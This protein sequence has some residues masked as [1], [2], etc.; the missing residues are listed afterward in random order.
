MH[1]LDVG[2]GSG[3]SGIQVRS[4]RTKVVNFRAVNCFASGVAVFGGDGTEF[5]FMGNDCEIINVTLRNTNFGMGEPYD[6]NQNWTQAG[7]MRDQ[8][9][10]NTYRNI[11]IDGCGGPFFYCNQASRLAKL[12]GG[13]FRNG[14]QVSV[15]GPAIVLTQLPTVPDRPEFKDIL[16]DSTNGKITDLVRY[17]QNSANC[18][19]T[20]ENVRGVGITGALF[21][22]AYVNDN[23]VNAIG[24][25]FG[26]YRETVPLNGATTFSLR[27]RIGSRF[28]VN[29]TASE[30][31]VTITD[32][33]EGQRILIYGGTNPLNVDHGVGADRIFLKGGTAIVLTSNQSVEI[34]RRGTLW[35]EI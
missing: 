32:C 9:L 21:R 5:D 30:H 19:P 17:L 16:V 12:T 33:V 7:A 20:T 22:S 8:G 35:Y 27:G 25:G 15:A 34:E 3:R 29:P 14:R 23:Q 13:T 11:E 2:I 6:G 4:R 10:R 31:L 18:I 28:N 26:G 24:E 1:V